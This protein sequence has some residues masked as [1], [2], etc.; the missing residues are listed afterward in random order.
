MAEWPVYEGNNLLTNLLAYWDFEESSGNVIDE[1]NSYDLRAANAPT[2][3]AT[4][5]IT[6]AIS[7]V[8]ASNQRLY[9][10]GELANLYGAIGYND[11]SC[12]VWI[13]ITGDTTT[14]RGIVAFRG[15][16]YI[17]IYLD[18]AN[19]LRVSTNI[20]GTAVYAI[21]DNAMSTDT[22]YHVVFLFDRDSTLRLYVNNTL[23][24]G[25]ADISS[26]STS[27]MIWDVDNGFTI[28]GNYG[29][30]ASY[31]FTGVVDEMAVYNRLL[32]TDEISLLYNSGSGL[33]Y[34]SFN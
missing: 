31:A 27:N 1:V 14:T 3:S 24:T 32:T 18:T 21:S 25:T 20:T 13:K 22:W 23:Q 16:H 17:Y 29:T 15:T 12:S 33:P 30:N 6:N 11:V 5:I 8:R 2:Y 9:N 10:Y 4:G 7:Y 26:G 34:S 19:K 28:I